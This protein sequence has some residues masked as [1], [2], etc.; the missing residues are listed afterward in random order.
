MTI[1]VLENRDRATAR[2]I[3]QNE[4]V[5]D[6]LQ[7]EYRRNHIKRLNERICNGNNGAVFLDLIGTL[8]RIS[9]HCRNIAY[10]AVGE[11]YA[12]NY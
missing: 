6:Q 3:D 9:D 4:K 5:I 10:Y 12:S 2:R 8:E 7:A 11:G 1:D